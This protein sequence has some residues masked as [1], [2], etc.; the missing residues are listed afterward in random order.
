MHCKSILHGET[1]KMCCQYITQNSQQPQWECNCAIISAASFSEIY[2]ITVWDFLSFHRPSHSL[3]TNRPQSQCRSDFLLLDRNC[4]SLAQ[5]KQSS[6]RGG[7]LPNLV[8]LKSGGRFSSVE[9]HFF[10]SDKTVISHN[11]LL[12]IMPCVLLRVFVKS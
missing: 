4:F 5:R 3:L 9:R 1:S 12:V 6:A 8:M 7:G 11:F 2:D 10:F